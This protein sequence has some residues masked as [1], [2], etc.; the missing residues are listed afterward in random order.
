MKGTA[1]RRIPKDTMGGH[2]IETVKRLRERLDTLRALLKTYEAVPYNERDFVQILHLKK[3]I[4]ATRTG[5][6]S[7]GED[8]YW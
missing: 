2:R 8:S 6:R 4:D 5:L 3:R 7:A 1:H